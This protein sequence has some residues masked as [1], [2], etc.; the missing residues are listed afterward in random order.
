MFML[1]QKKY[2]NITKCSF[3]FPANPIKSEASQQLQNHKQ[4]EYNQHHNN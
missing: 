2:S 4:Y 1:P 3:A